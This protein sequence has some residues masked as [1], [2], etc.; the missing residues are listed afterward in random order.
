MQE[1]K[2]E[3][4]GKH[5]CGSSL[6]CCAAETDSQFIFTPT[7][8]QFNKNCLYLGKKTFCLKN[9]Q[10]NV[11]NQ[12]VN[13]LNKVFLEF[14]LAA[15]GF[16]QLSPVSREALFFPGCK[17]AESPGYIIYSV[18]KKKAC[19]IYDLSAEGVFVNVDF[20]VLG[21]PEK[22]TRKGIPRQSGGANTAINFFTSLCYLSVS[23]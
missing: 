3:M 17:M 22:N 18:E 1:Q 21:H 23:I 4:L 20:D 16:L 12:S 14:N 9:K 15:D 11:G 13:V 2:K 10:V 6:R 5:F 8:L 7:V 19:S